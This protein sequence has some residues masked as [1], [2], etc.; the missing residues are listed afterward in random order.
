MFCDSNLKIE[1]I[2]CFIDSFFWRSFTD[3]TFID[4]GEICSNG[5]S[6][7]KLKNGSK[8]EETDELSHFS[9]FSVH[10]Q[11]YLK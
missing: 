4:S 7:K 5:S 6:A 9:S 10:Q 3:D 11:N 1:P 8:I 2:I